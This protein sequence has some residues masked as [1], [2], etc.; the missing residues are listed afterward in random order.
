MEML[1]MILL[2]SPWMYPGGAVCSSFFLLAFLLSS[3]LSSPET[4]VSSLLLTKTYLY[5]S[6]LRSVNKSPTRG[7]LVGGKSQDT[8]DGVDGEDD[9][10]SIEP[11]PGDVDL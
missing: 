5:E 9:G 11:C 6:S 4:A 3:A 1:E 10:L 7:C 2:M 8:L